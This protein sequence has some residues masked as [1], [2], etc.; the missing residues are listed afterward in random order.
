MPHPKYVLFLPF[1][2][3]QQLTNYQLRVMCVVVVAVVVIVVV[4]VVD[5]FAIHTEQILINIR[6]HELNKT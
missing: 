2:R 4:V 6:N 5:T 1:I 3:G